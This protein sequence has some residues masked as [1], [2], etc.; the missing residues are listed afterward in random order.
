MLLLM[1]ETLHPKDLQGFLHP[2]WLFGI[3]SIYRS[4]QNPE[5]PDL[6]F[7]VPMPLVLRPLL[8]N[9]LSFDTEQGEFEAAGARV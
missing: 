9:H 5:F 8:E 2:R 3:S 6:S 7:W 1:A 4:T